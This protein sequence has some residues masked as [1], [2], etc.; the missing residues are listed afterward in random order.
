MLKHWSWKIPPD[1]SIEVP[2]SGAK[3]WSIASLWALEKVDTCKITISFFIF[4][5]SVQKNT[6]ESPTIM[7]AFPSP[8]M[9][10]QPSTSGTD[11]SI[12]RKGRGPRKAK[13]VATVMLPTMERRTGRDKW[14]SETC[15]WNK[16]SLPRAI[17]AFNMETDIYPPNTSLIIINICTNLNKTFCQIGVQ[18]ACL[19]IPRWEWWV[20]STLPGRETSR[21]HRA[22]C[23]RPPLWGGAPAS[24]QSSRCRQSMQSCPG[25]AG[26]AGDSE[27]RK[28]S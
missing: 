20:C 6:F 18:C 10:T 23:H 16:K 22:A 5:A 11:G 24:P 4:F 25:M 12:G 2:M 17:F 7:S 1:I 8:A 26:G 28:C 3:P 9:A 14:L 13:Q 19:H 21:P 27:K 15:K